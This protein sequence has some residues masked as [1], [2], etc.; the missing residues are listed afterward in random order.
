MQKGL[1]IL[2]WFL[3]Y[4]SSAIDLNLWEKSDSDTT[5]LAIRGQ[6]MMKAGFTETLRLNG[7]PLF[8]WSHPI[9]TWE[10]DL[11]TTSCQIALGSQSAYSRNCANK[12]KAKIDPDTN[13]AGKL[14]KA[15]DLKIGKNDQIYYIGENPHASGNGFEIYEW[16]EGTGEGLKIGA[17]TK[18]AVDVNGYPWIVD[19]S[20]DIKQWVTSSFVDKPGQATD[21]II[22][23][24][25]TPLIVGT[26]PTEGGKIIQKWNTASNSWETLLGIGGVSL[27]LDSQENPYVVT[28]DHKVYR[29]K[30]LV[31]SF[32]PGKPNILTFSRI[33]SMYHGLCQLCKLR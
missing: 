13:W 10:E 30:G 23:D 32:C 27:A 20:N 28:E 31:Y 1:L 12:V 21:I 6:K 24:N 5:Y 7:H 19:S 3:S 18:V 11:V 15:Q 26:T 9:Q 2:F 33:D 8:T 16:V 14:F 25:N 29:Q 17:A 22:G 4:S